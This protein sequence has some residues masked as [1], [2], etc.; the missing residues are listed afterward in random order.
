MSN[1]VSYEARLHNWLALNWSGDFPSMMPPYAGPWQQRIGQYLDKYNKVAVRLPRQTGKSTALRAIAAA[2][3]AC[4]DS[5]ILASPSLLQSGRILLG[6]I[7][8]ELYSTG[9]QLGLKPIEKV[10]YFSRW[11]SGGKIVGLSLSGK[12]Q[13]EGYTSG[14][15]IIDEAQAVMV[16][17]FEKLPPSISQA[18][19]S[20][21]FKIIVTGIGSKNP[22]SLLAQSHRRMG[23]ELLHVSPEEIIEDDPSYKQVFNEFHETLTQQAYHLNIDVLDLDGTARQLYP[24]IPNTLTYIKQAEKMPRQL[25]IGID[26][27]L[28]SDETVVLVCER[29]WNQRNIIA[30]HKPKLGFYDKQAL[31]IAEFLRDV[32]GVWAGGCVETNGYGHGLYQ[33][34]VKP[35]NGGLGLVPKITPVHLNYSLKVGAV[36]KIKKYLEEGSLGTDDPAIRQELSTLVET[37]SGKDEG[38]VH[39]TH[40]DIHSAL[41]QCILAGL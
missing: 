16:E 2:T 13:V 18:I 9:A 33:E 40:S 32:P 34:L 20:G 22:N 7:H 8:N 3:V 4:G 25:Y 10:G 28:H 35:Y 21:T 27:G 6:E 15:L 12:A 39:Y 31:Q 29:I 5:V 24:S 30:I 41:I 19:R 11:N 14:L 17:S 36:N 1:D 37:F 38:T 26:V 23:Y